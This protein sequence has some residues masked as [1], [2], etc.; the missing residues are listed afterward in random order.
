MK[1]TQVFL[2]F[3]L[4]GMGL[5]CNAQNNQDSEQ[6][7]KD[8]VK[9]E[10]VDV[11]FFHM[12][13]RCLTCKSVQNVAKQAVEELGKDHVNFHELNVEKPEGKEKAKKMNVSGQALLVVGGDQKINI[14]R[15]GFMYARSKPEKLKE[16]VHQKINSL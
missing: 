6:K 11:Y 9:A 8:Q 14:T 15:E 1:I 3:I 4:A 16:I 5:A 2:I 12:P 13:R 7:K 10:Q